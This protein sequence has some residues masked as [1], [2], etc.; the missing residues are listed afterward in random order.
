MSTPVAG[1][2]GTSHTSIALVTGASSGI[3][4]TY[5]DRLARRGHDLVLV[6]RD[7]D[8]LEAL[9]AR[10]R[11][12]AGVAVEVLPA[13]LSTEAGIAAVERRLAALPAVGLLV[14]NAGIGPEGPM[15][16]S[17]VGHL[18]RMVA[19]NVQAVNRLTLAA[20]TAF[21]ARGG[22]TIVNIASV[23]ALVPE[24]FNATYAA[25]KAFVL[26]LTQS[27]AAELSGRG[28]R[29]Q[30]VLPGLTR[31]E[32][33]DRVGRSFDALDPAMVMDAGDMVDAALAG[34]DAGEA[35]T[36]PSLEDGSAFEAA[37]AARLA[38]GPN[39]SKDRPAS[40]YRVA[41]AV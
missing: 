1:E 35:I 7:A 33:F 27:L 2:A 11:T 25:T 6:A 22:G 8:R 18:D 19:V 10:L 34:L 23:V 14:N 26:A 17:T 40:R 9:A 37:T 24:M 13:D 16:R 32:I 38:L 12:Q 29:L 5:A 39:L 4:A 15:L 3:G 30:A 36:I 41:A 20:A 31:T 21:A 28:V